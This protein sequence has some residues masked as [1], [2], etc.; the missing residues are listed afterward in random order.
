MRRLN[1]SECVYVCN[2]DAN[3]CSMHAGLL[4][5][6]CLGRRYGVLLEYPGVLCGGCVWQRCKKKIITFVY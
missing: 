1:V 6:R 5:G 4:G 2:D 3:V